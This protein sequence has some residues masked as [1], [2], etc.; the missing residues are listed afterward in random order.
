MSQSTYKIESLTKGTLVTVKINELPPIDNMVL[1][2]NC[3][4]PGLYIRFR[5]T[6]LNEGE[7]YF[8]EK[9]N[10]DIFQSAFSKSDMVDLRINERREFDKDVYDDLK[11][12][13][14][15]LDFK[16]FHF[17]F[18]GSSENDKVSGNTAYQDCRLWDNE[19]WFSYHES[20]GLENKYI[21][22]SS[23]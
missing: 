20:I 14:Y 8:V 9:I 11:K 3:N 16:K 23:D 22:L 19:R 13:R 5:V 7:F 21:V 6:E 2:Q 10:N 4:G 18:I 1:P 12:D 15:F 17:F